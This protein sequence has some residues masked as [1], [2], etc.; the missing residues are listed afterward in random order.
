MQKIWRKNFLFKIFELFCAF[1]SSLVAHTM[2]QI[3]R[4]NWKN[5]FSKK[6]QG[7]LPL[8]VKFDAVQCIRLDA[9]V[10]KIQKIRFFLYFWALNFAKFQQNLYFSNLI[11][12]SNVLY[13][14]SAIHCIWRAKMVIFFK[15][16]SEISSFT[17][18][19]TRNHRKSQS[20]GFCRATPHWAVVTTPSN[21]L[22]FASHQLTEKSTICRLTNF[23]M[24]LKR[25]VIDRICDLLIFYWF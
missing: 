7:L 4:A 10:L 9:Q 5:S 25:G 8:S 3:W 17:P 2:H 20:P 12:R 11:V 14:I 6:N 21:I 1:P 15:I 22:H 13:A 18:K 24:M 16:N 23:I 19:L